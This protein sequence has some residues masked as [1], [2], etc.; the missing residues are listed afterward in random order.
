M[1]GHRFTQRGT[2]T[3]YEIAPLRT[4]IPPRRTRWMFLWVSLSDAC[5]PRSLE[6]WHRMRRG[7]MEA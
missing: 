2:I 6:D 3:N 7:S 5:H 4:E 1:N